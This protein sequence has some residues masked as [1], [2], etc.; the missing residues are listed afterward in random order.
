MKKVCENFK[1]PKMASRQLAAHAS[2]GQWEHALKTLDLKTIRRCLSIEYLSTVRLDDPLAE[3]SIFKLLQHDKMNDKQAFHLLR[4]ALTAEYRMKTFYELFDSNLTT[5]REELQLNR[6]FPGLGRIL[7]EAVK[8]DPTR[9]LNNNPVIV[10]FYLKH[11]EL[12]SQELRDE[13]IPCLKFLHPL[14]AAAAKRAIDAVLPEEENP[15]ATESQDDEE[16]S[17]D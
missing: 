10:L 9:Y 5:Q 16:T 2:K 8:A 4:L 14:K 6:R 13:L 1:K 12:D 17:S 11:F 7:L 3:M 15:E